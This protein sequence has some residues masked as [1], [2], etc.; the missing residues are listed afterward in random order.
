M[1]VKPTPAKSPQ[2]GAPGQRRAGAFAALRVRDYRYFFF[3]QLVSN[4][5]TW[6]Q[7][8][9]QDW[10]V[11]QLTG[12]ALNVGI[13]SALQFLPI[14]V[15]G[16]F[17][18]A[19]ADRYPRRLLL[20]AAQTVLGLCA[21]LLA[22]ATLTG[23]VTLGFVFGLALVSGAVNAVSNPALQSFVADVVGPE[24]LGNAISLGA[25]NFQSARLVGP[26]VSG[27]LISAVGTGWAFAVNAASYAVVVASLLAVRQS[28]QKPKPRTKGQVREGLRYVRRRGEL[29]RPITLVGFVCTFGYNFPTIFSGF[30]SGTF[31]VA[32]G[33][34]ALMTTALGVGAVAGALLTARRGRDGGNTPPRVLL[35]AAGGFAGAELV[36]ALAPGYASFVAVM[37][38]VGG[39]SIV[40]NTTANTT[41]QMATD[42]AMRGRVM[43]LYSLVYS[44]GTTVGAP[45]LGWA[46]DAWGARASLACCAGLAAAGTLVVA[47]ALRGD[48]GPDTA[49]T[50]S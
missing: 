17:G 45:L 16:L 1:T 27:V 37:V 15:L 35:Y 2:D 24:H 4:T 36:A 22:V 42:P 8:V 19:L 46:M 3:G 21:A 12:R 31:H 44:G 29:L 33:R 26:A 40:F 32:A 5:G 13:T 43:G 38:L 10:L 50:G 47:T 14:L 48:R 11:L 34:Y 49:D 25:L 6:V 23:H 41:V 18:G 30:A 28:A 9:A 7:F 20:M 39:L